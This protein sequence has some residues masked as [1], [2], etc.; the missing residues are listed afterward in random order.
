VDG[1]NVIGAWP[2]LREMRD[3]AG[4]EESRQLL[5]ESLIGYSAFQALDTRIVFDAQYQGSPSSQE[6]ITPNVSIHYTDFGQTADSYI[7][8][9]CASYRSHVQLLGQRVIVATSDRVQQITVTG[10]GAEWISALRLLNDIESTARRIK[11][12]Q[13]SKK[14][15]SSRLLSSRLDPAVQERLSAMRFGHPLPQPKSLDG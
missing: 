6:T 5:V 15:Q 4:L 11:Q 8:K 9:L 1:Y 14:R 12:T 13:H 2:S 7:E 10:Y 3:R